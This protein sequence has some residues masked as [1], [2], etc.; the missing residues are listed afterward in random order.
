MSNLFIT[1]YGIAQAALKNDS[2][3]RDLSECASELSSVEL[4][5]AILSPEIVSLM[6]R[7]DRAMLTSQSK[8]C[9]NV[10]FSAMKMA[11]GDVKFTPAEKEAMCVYS[12]FE[13]IRDFHDVVWAFKSSNVQYA[14]KQLLLRRLGCMSS[15]VH[16]LRLF[17]KLPTN[18]LYHLS[19]IFELRGGGYPLRKMSLGGLSLLEEAFYNLSW[20]DACGALICAY[21]DMSKS[22]N[23]E[24]FRKMGLLDPLDSSRSRVRGTEGAVSLVVETEERVLLKDIRPIAQVLLAFSRY[25]TNMFAT[26]QDWIEAYKHVDDWVR[27]SNPVVVLY[28][29]GAPGIGDA[30]VRALESCFVSFEVRRYKQLSKYAVATSGLVDLVCALADSSIE[31]G[32]VIVIHG[33]GAGVGLSLIVLRKLEAPLSQSAGALT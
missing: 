30:E 6:A 18:S 4:N 3:S 29:N 17:R 25:S 11:E 32:R 31:P 20:S 26:T 22:D 28:D 10:G 27:E 14:E 19:K 1:G 8:H 15:I 13:T 9:L 5:E 2:L 23:A 24:V 21:G 33:E 12:T 7:E 16:P